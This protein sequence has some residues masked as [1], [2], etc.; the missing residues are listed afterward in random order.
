MIGNRE[1]DIQAGQD[2]GCTTILVHARDTQ[3]FG[4]NHVC[5]EVQQAVSLILYKDK[6]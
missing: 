2:V 4:A 6:E 1:P 3:T 5:S